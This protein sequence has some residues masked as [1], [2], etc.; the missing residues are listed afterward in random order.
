M[1]FLDRARQ[2]EH[3]AGAPR[4]QR[5]SLLGRG[6]IGELAQRGAKPPD[7]DPQPRTMRFIRASGAKG[8]GDQ[9]IMAFRAWLLAEAADARA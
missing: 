2:H 6:D 7:L 4:L 9:R 3:L 8:A 5:K 1:F